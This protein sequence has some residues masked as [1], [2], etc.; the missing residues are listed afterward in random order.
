MRRF[1]GLLVL[2]GC[3]AT[4]PGA[5]EARPNIVVILADDLGFS[6][7]GCYGGEIATPN[8]DR[9]AANGLRF[10]QFYNTS[11]CCP[12]RASLLTGLY[13]HQT[14]VGHLVGKS[15][16]PGDLSR[17]CPTVAEHLKKAGYAT[18]M[19]GKWHLTPWPGPP[20]NGPYRRGFDRFY[21]IIASIRSYYNPPSLTQDDRPLP[22]PG[23]DYHFTDAL[24]LEAARFIDEH[25]DPAQP[26]FLYVAQ[27]APHWPLH[28]RDR[29]RRG[30]DPGGR[31]DGR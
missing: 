26:F 6:D 1:L 23:G 24:N 11:R 28:A 25:R 22:A 13:P 18:Y 17:A 9:L 12:T 30:W 14:G 10:T 21:G 19:T 16:Y 7:L 27:A 3:T 4:S 2:S 8:L 29:Y 15:T 31:G 20:D 5:P